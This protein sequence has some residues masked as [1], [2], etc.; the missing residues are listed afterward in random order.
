MANYPGYNYY[1]G[2]PGFN[3]YQQ[4]QFQQQPVPQPVQQQ[5]AFLCVPVA[6]REEALAQRAEAFGPGILMPDFGHGVI[7]FKRFNEKTALAD[8]SVFQLA[9]SEQENAAPALDFGTVVSAVTSR[10]DGMDKKIDAI[11]D[12]LEKP[13]R[14]AAKSGVE[15]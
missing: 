12:R 1:G 11:A 2:Y 15:K 3:P 8:F 7:Y 6:S 4:A 10:L 13:V 9:P 5:P 14:T